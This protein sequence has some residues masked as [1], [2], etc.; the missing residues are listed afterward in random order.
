MAFEKLPQSRA[1]V[2]YD[3][4]RDVFRFGA[5]EIYGKELKQR[6]AT[7]PWEVAAQKEAEKQEVANRRGISSSVFGQLPQGSVATGLKTIPGAQML[8]DNRAKAKAELKSPIFA[9]I[10]QKFKEMEEGPAYRDL[11]QAMSDYAN[12]VYGRTQGGTTGD[13]PKIKS[14]AYRTVGS[15]SYSA[16]QRL[17][18][19]RSASATLGA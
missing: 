6:G 1:G 8:I 13:R 9:S 15:E 19:G 17:T 18:R 11:D 16:T 14:K 7:I 10:E 3:K 12:E 2:E 4:A 5:Y